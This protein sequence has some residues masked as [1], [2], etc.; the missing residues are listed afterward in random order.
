MATLT[1]DLG[2][3][4]LTILEKIRGVS[5]GLVVLVFTAACFGIAVLYS[6]ADGNMQPWAAAQTIRFAIALIPMIGAALV[7]IR[8]WFRAAYWAY[9][10]A[11]ALVVAVD[12]R[13]FVGMGAR[14]WIDLGVIQLQPSE[15]MN[16]ALVLGL[17]RYF[18]TLSNEDVRR[19]RFLFPPAIMVLLPAAL[20]LK[21]P[22]LGT[23]IMLLMTGAVL[24]FIAGVRLRI[25]F[26]MA[27][28]TAAAVPAGWHFLRDYQK[29]RIYT[30]LDPESDPLGAGYHI[31][32]S[33]IALGSGGLFGKGFLLGSQSHLS[34]LPEKQTDFVFTTLA[35]EFGFV[36]GL[37]LL[38]LYT[39]IIGY[40]F[41]IAFRCRSH[42]GRL[43]GLGI[44][45]NFSLYVFINTAMVMGLIPV[46]GV[47]LPLISYGGTA[48]LAVM[49]GFG[50]LL[51]VGVHR[52]VRLNQRGESQPG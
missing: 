23:A 40:G 19:V 41:V 7:G 11:L 52:D 43:L 39:L 24:F 18:H 15:L 49:F 4:E 22:D 13:G 42:F 44:V 26:L 31:L 50:L 28:A 37:G 14:R 9:A 27:I 45:T 3:R 38:A 5:W 33:K 34:F 16:V 2:R 21:Q 1:S 6:A 10:M 35:E 17:A 25:F 47:P 46:V 36:G 12:L 8:L 29:N 48:M 51:N 32:Q 30:F 20:V